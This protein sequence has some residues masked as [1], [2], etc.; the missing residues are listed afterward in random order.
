MKKCI[1]C[2]IEKSLESFPKRNDNKLFRGECKECSA[3]ISK[4]YRKNNRSKMKLY[5]AK[6]NYGVSL[7]EAEILYKKENCDIC[8]NKFINSKTKHIDHC[9]KNKNIRG[10]LCMSCNHG[11]GK[12]RDDISLLQKAIEYLNKGTLPVVIP[13][14]L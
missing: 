11:I 6:W 9:H 7:E 2:N 13:M 5:E 10:V 14:Q 1:K 8:G 3:I 4:E 12:F